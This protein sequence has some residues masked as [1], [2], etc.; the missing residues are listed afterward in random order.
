MA[1][2]SA[3]MTIRDVLTRIDSSVAVPPVGGG[4]QNG[5]KDLVTHLAELWTTFHG[6]DRVQTS[7]VINITTTTKVSF[8]FEIDPNHGDSQLDVIFRDD[9]RSTN[10]MYN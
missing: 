3:L 7:R 9:M 10:S 2:V 6:V 4:G 5:A 1:A 8:R